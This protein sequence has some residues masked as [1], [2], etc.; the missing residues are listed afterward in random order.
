MK[1]M[2]KEGCEFAFLQEK[3]PWISM[4]KLKDGIFD[5]LQLRELMKDPMFNESLSEVE[6]STWQ[7]LKSEVTN[8]LGN[9]L[10]VECE[11][12]IEKLL[13]SFRQ[14]GARTSVKL[15]FIRPT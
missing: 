13:K 8:F 3:F 12:E 5:G 15:H 10:S 9:Q 6:P 2:D 14:L 11:K 4:E 1:V 7:S